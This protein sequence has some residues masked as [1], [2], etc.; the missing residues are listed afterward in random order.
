MGG[1]EVYT[2]TC[3]NVMEGNLERLF[4]E[5]NPAHIGA[6]TPPLHELATGVTFPEDWSRVTDSDI[7]RL[8]NGRAS[9][10]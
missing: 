9:F 2:P 6:S 7:L 1:G 3:V 10:R 4:S 8:V 5:D